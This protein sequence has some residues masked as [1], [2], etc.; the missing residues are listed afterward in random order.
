MSVP[1]E[2]VRPAAFLLDLYG[3]LVDIHTDENQP[4]LWK[5]MAGFVLSRG[6]DWE[7]KALHR[8]YLEAVHQEEERPLSLPGSTGKRAS[9]RTP[10]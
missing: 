7:E 8:A 10:R 6:A 5:R 9:G 1:E 4:S 2:T 3:T